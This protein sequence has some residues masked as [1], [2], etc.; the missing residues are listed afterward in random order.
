MNKIIQIVL[1]ITLCLC[2]GLAFAGCSEK[3]RKTA[4]INAEYTKLL[5]DCA[6]YFDKETKEFKVEY[7]DEVTRL[8]TDDSR[9]GLLKYYFEPITKSA[10]SFFVQTN[11][12]IGDKNWS[13][14]SRTAIYNKLNKTRKALQDFDNAKQRFQNSLAGHPSGQQMNTMELVDYACFVKAY[15]DFID[16]VVEFGD[17]TIKAFFNDF[18]SNFYTYDGKSERENYDLKILLKH[19]A[20]EIAKSSIALE[21]RQYFDLETAEFDTKV[22]AGSTTKLCVEMNK[23]NALLTKANAKLTDE[24]KLASYKTLIDKQTFFEAQIDIFNTALKNFDFKKMNNSDETEE[25][26]VKKAT[27]AQQKYYQDIFHIAYDYIPQVVADYS[28]EF[29]KF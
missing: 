15:S 8:I 20:F 3:E 22:S 7:S 28:T 13:V 23:V 14:K 11:G 29:N 25:M 24:T 19:K 1:S 12:T 5:T 10:F 16:V 6:S 18:Y 21:Y 9:A 26:Y 27:V 17:T 2:V 4:D